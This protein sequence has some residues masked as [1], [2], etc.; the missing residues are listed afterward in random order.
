MIA[1]KITGTVITQR[2]GVL[3]SGDILRTDEA[4]TRHL[5]ED[6][7]AGIYIEPAAPVAVD[8][9]NPPKTTRRRKAAPKE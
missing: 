1:V 5:V 3:S 4:F 2:Y 6:C 8:T 7:H 9:E